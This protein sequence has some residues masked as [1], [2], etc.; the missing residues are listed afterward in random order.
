MAKNPRGKTSDV[1]G[2]WLPRSR[3][4]RYAYILDNKLKCNYKEQPHPKEKG[5]IINKPCCNGKQYVYDNRFNQ[6]Y[7][8]PYCTGKLE[9]F[10]ENFRIY[11]NLVKSVS[12]VDFNLE[13]YINENIQCEDKCRAV[14]FVYKLN[15]YDCIIEEKYDM[16]SK[17]ILNKIEN[18]T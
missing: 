15:K 1:E 14:S 12:S 2:V 10:D 5:V 11:D 4:H 16:F 9:K 13:Q 17:I 7:T 6:Y 18:N 8:C 3:K